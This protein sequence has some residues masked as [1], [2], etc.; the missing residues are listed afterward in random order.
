MSE[1]KT[2]HRIPG[3]DLARFLAVFGFVVVDMVG[4]V[5]WSGGGFSREPEGPIALNWMW[6]MW[7]GRASAMLAVLAGTGLA[8]MFR[9]GQEPDAIA[10]K[11]GVLLRRCLFLFV[12]GHLWNS[13]TLWSWSILH[14]YPFYLALGLLFVKARPRVLALT[15]ALVVTIATVDALAFRDTPEWKQ[16][17]SAAEQVEQ[18]D[19]AAA[20]GGE[21]EG[22]PE[23]PEAAESETATRS[24]QAEENDKRNKEDWDDWE[25]DFGDPKIWQAEFWS[26]R[27]HVDATLFDGIYPLFPWLAFVLIGMWVVRMGIGEVTRRRRMLVLAIA[28]MAVSFGASWAARHFGW[29]EAAETLT[30]TERYPGMP[31]Y[32]LSAAGQAVGLMCLCLSA[33]SRWPKARWIPPLVATGQMTFTVYIFRHFIGGGD[34]SGLFDW[35]GFAT[36]E[37][38][39]RLVDG[40]FRV[41]VFVPLLIWL[42]YLCVRRFG[43]GP[44]EAAM[45]R[46]SDRPDAAP[47]RNP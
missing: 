37:T 11:R 35:I 1:E 41:A 20:T 15:A 39:A 2:S 44:L 3:Y 10:R 14:Y 29:G 34:R 22:R 30:S 25:G 9:I 6:Q 13:S 47:P 42:C 32:I 24:D 21:P 36:G 18:G 45:R 27:E 17:E 8:L 43:R 5:L 26:L 46:F 40:W 28:A 23:N 16:P 12:A 33:A 38:R 4:N 19:S 7:W 31:L